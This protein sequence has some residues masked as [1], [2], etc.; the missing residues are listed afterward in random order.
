MTEVEEVDRG[1]VVS[2]HEPDL[3]LSHE[4]GHGH[5]EIIANHDDALNTGWVAL[6]QRPNELGF[7]L[8]AHL[9]V[10]PS[11]N[12]FVSV[13]PEYSCMRHVFE[14]RGASGPRGRPG[15]PGPDVT[16]RI[17][18]LSSPFYENLVVSAVQVGAAPPFYVMA[19]GDYVPPADWLKV[20]S[21]GGTGGRGAAGRN[22]ADGAPQ[23]DASNNIAPLHFTGQ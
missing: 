9:K 14:F 11:A 10:K 22:G 23:Q 5:P 4:P 16:V 6:P 19:N 3:E 8:S 15:A 20:A 13:D 7:R 12:G 2:L 18:M 1:A 17:A 21:I